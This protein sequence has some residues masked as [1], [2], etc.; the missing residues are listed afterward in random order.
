MK[1]FLHITNPYPSEKGSEAD[2]IQQHT[3]ASLSKARYNS[4]QLVVKQIHLCYPEEKILCAEDAKIQPLLS[5]SLADFCNSSKKKLPLLSEILIKGCV[6]ANEEYIIYTNMDIIISLDFYNV[7]NK[8]IDENTDAL[9]INRRR[10][11]KKFLY[12][13]TEEQYLLF[14]ET[15][16]THPGFDCFVFKKSLLDQFILGN[17]CVGIPHAETCLAHNIF[18]FSKKCRLIT[19]AHVTFHIGIELHK[20]WGTKK[21]INHN[22]NEF[23]TVLKKLKPF[24][25]IENFPG[26]NLMFIKRHFKWLMNPL[27]HYPTIA[28]LDLQQWNKPRYSEKKYEKLSLKNKYLEWLIKQ[29][30]F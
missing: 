5:K 26:S 7:I 4:K 21:E 22:Y 27:F 11:A 3:I 25:K 29:V 12:T 6:N 8:W 14:S 1:S 13:N 17:T 28:Q 23:R 15:G 16:K 10:I 30:N 18:A 19:D 9:I 20:T 2:F 24:L